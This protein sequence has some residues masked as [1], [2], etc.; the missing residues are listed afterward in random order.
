M[1]WDSIGSA[2][3]GG[4]VVLPNQIQAYIVHIY[5]KG[6]FTL[7]AQKLSYECCILGILFESDKNL[8]LEPN[9][10]KEHMI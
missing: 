3:K 1:W 6:A 10:P 4:A 7:L 5:C 8:K 9:L 2:S